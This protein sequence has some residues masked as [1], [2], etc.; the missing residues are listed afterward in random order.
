MAEV[1][2]IY[3]VT[4]VART[5]ADILPATD[6]ERAQ[7]RPAPTTRGKWLTTSVTDD[8]AQVIGGGLRR[9]HPAVTRSSVG[10]GSSWS[11]ATTTSSTGSASKPANA[12]S[13]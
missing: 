5:V 13:P 10:T 3:D 11:T 1:G 8:A 9:G 4:P 6:A 2:A 7:A 12:R